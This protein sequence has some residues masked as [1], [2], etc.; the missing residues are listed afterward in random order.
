[1]GEIRLPRHMFL[2]SMSVIY[3]FAFASLYIQLPGL[4]GNEGI[5]P[6]RWQM[7]YTG[8][9]LL[10]QLQDSPTLLW[11]G[12]HL[13]L[14]TQQGM[15]LVCLLGVL[16]AFGAMVLDALRDSLVF[17]CLW[18][19]YLSLYQVGQVFLYFQ[20]DNLLLETGFLA[21]LIAPLNLFRGK[22]SSKYHDGITFWLIRWLFFR[23]MFASGAV[24]LTS[25]C[26]TWWGLTALTYHYETQCLPTP[27]A[28]HAHQLPVWFQK[29]SV[30]GTFVIEIA[31]PFLFFAPI[32]SLRLG[33]FYVQLALQVVIILTGNY[34]FFNLLSIALSFSLLDDDSVNSWLGRSKKRKPK[35]EGRGGWAQSCLIPARQEQF[36]LRGLYVMAWPEA[37]ISWSALLVEL[38]VYALI[39]YLSK[40]YFD[41]EINW[42]TKRVASKTAFTYHQF[43]HFLQTVTIPSI[44]IGVLSL[45]WEVVTAMF[46][47]ACVRG[48]FWKLWVT[49]QWAIFT[50]AAAGMFA[51]SVVPYTFIDYQSNSHI[52]PGVRKAYESLDRY[53][54]VNSYGLFR[55]M[56][57]VGG[58][59]EVV[60]EGSMDKE[61]WTE[62]EFMF[63]PGNVS[64]PPFFVAPHQPRLDWQ[65]WFAALGPHSQSPWFTSL[66]HRL[67][68]GKK[69]V[70]DLIQVDESNYPFSQEPPAFIRAH[71]YKYWF[72]ET[73]E[74]GSLPRQ[75]WRRNFVEEFY[76]TVHLG[77][78]TLD[79][80]LSQ[81]GLKDK[82]PVRRALDAPL[83]QALE[84]VREHVRALS[85]PLVLWSLF[86]T[87]TAI[88]LLKV[89]FSATSGASRP[90]PAPAEPKSKRAKEAPVK[91]ESAEESELCDGENETS[92]ER[93]VDSDRSPRKRK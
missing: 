4:Y 51:L 17:L 40:L 1:M 31:F 12:P 18:A 13:G 6:A 49:I 91:K 75:W 70:I 53:Q 78:P 37:L 43:S 25:R 71:L 14:D 72:T 61:T 85:G 5:L 21:V 32:R 63:K 44:W 84:Q 45:T 54:L 88:C 27:L 68:Q 34:N 80:M 50:T 24:K 89:L 28:W 33:A 2:W 19:L 55:R 20:W 83:P 76:P 10:E 52:W 90:K 57:G 3:M 60:I 77:D 35:E 41:L 66:V 7:R 93:A 82:G 79:N 65:M 23:L 9:A 11:L 56:T 30:V 86:A 58:R 47:C 81:L 59:P 26:P 38:G 16:L 42:K 48:F 69:D 8:K 87:G 29:I 22:S 15:E 74:D 62:I 67:L 92:E 73:S 64:A 36:A 39:I 46:K